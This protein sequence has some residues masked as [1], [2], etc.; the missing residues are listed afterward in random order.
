MAGMKAKTWLFL[1]LAGWLVGMPLA[2]AADV[3]ARAL[4][5][6]GKLKEEAFFAVVAAQERV[7]G[8]EDNLQL[9]RSVERE[10]A[11]SG[12]RAAIQV[13]RQAVSEGEQGV[14]EARQLLE[15]AKALL[16]RREEQLTAI[17]VLGAREKPKP[18]GLRGAM[19][20]LEGEVTVFDGSGRAVG[21]RYRPLQVGDRVVTGKDGRVRLFLAGGD[22]DALLEPGSDFRIT[23]DSLDGGFLADLKKGSAKVRVRVAH[24][25]RKFEVR[26]PSGGGAVRGT[27]FS[28][29]ALHEGMRV[30]VWEGVVAVS[31]S[32][33]GSSPVELRA[34]EQREWTRAGGWGPLQPLGGTQQRVQWGD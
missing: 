30:S 23:E 11:G 27:E 15:R 2:I 4:S 29:D 7:R 26:T 32:D 16:S 20:V 5:L 25:L 14:R 28:M 8:A 21:E 31:P 13:A 34:G 22:A 3:S 18:G 33:P 10:V 12:D 19:L 17:S 6:A 9:M 1:L 24:K